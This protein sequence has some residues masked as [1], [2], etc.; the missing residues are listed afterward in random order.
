MSKTKAQPR[1]YSFKCVSYASFEELTPLLNEAY[2]YALIYHDRD[3]EPDP[4]YHIL[5]TFKQNK[6]FDSVRKLVQSEKTTLAQELEDWVGDFQYLTHKNA[7]DK[8]QYLDEEVIS[9]DIDFWLR[10]SKEASKG[11]DDFVYDL[12]DSGM[13]YR[14]MAIKYGRDYMRN[15]RYYNEFKEAVLCQEAEHRKENKNVEN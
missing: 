9:D 6:S 13:S 10:K 12:L 11:E 2:H 15:F 4:H 8:Y 14:E 5:V 1:R 3:I 7:P